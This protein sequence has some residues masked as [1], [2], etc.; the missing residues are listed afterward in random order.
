MK[1][2]KLLLTT[3]LLLGSAIL[4]STQNA[5]IGDQPILNVQAAT[6]AN[7]ETINDVM[8][9]QQLQKLVLYEMKRQKIVTSD[10][11][12]SQ[13]DAGSFKTALGKLTSINWRTIPGYQRAD[14]EPINGGNGTIGPAS[15]NPGNYSL[16]GLENATNL[17]ELDLAHD[18]DYG[19]YYFDDVKDVT[20]LSGLTKLTDLNLEGNRI[21]DISPIAG[22][23]SVKNL[24]L[25]S[26]SIKN[27]NVLDRDNYDKFQYLGQHVVFPVQHLT[28]N[29]YTWKAPFKDA[30]PKHVADPTNH[31]EP[32]TS[33]NIHMVKSSNYYDLGG[34]AGE[35]DETDLIQVFKPA[36]QNMTLD[37]DDVHFAGLAEQVSPGEGISLAQ[38]G[39][40]VPEPGNGGVVAPSR[41]A[42]HINGTLLANEHTYYMMVKYRAE[43]ERAGYSTAVMS[44]H[45]PYVIDKVQVQ[46]VTVKYEDEKGTAIHGVQTITGKLGDSFDL[47]KTDYQ[48][49][50]PGYTFKA[51]DPIQTGEL[52]GQAQTV[53]LVYTKNTAPDVPVVPKNESINPPTAPD[54]PKTPSVP[55]QPVMTE[56]TSERQT[57]VAAPEN[58]AKIHE[59][60]YSLEKIYLYQNPTFKSSERKAGYVQKPRVFRPMF[61][62]DGYAH[63]KDGRL[64]YHVRDV[65]HQSKTDG[66]RGYITTQFAYVR[67][68]Y[69]HSSHKTL[70]A[71]NPKGVNEYTNKNLTNKVRNFK[72]GTVLR[73]KKFVTHNLTTR[74][75]LTNGH[76]VTGNRKLV[77]MGR[78]KQPKQVV[79]KQGLNRYRDADFTMKNG[80]FDKGDKIIVKRFT[81]SHQDS[82]K[83]GGTKRFEVKGGFISANPKLVR[84]YYK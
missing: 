40:L 83:Q 51:Y 39:G 44:Y 16:K 10:S 17:T 30:L 26:N 33:Q 50:I 79:L 27:L 37:G 23:R 78:H 71:I 14:Y 73:V 59:A 41:E 57:Q 46:P 4:F 12:L 2:H 29:A 48:L 74:Y 67:P 81:F 76:Y 19:R 80:H 84:A 13:F 6:V 1:I 62:V 24:I 25:I 18:L 77:K 32:Y 61:V 9:N 66:L 11:D 36:T 22:M 45:L 60:V 65:N 21:E 53:K 55:D 34:Y 49:E 35:E 52:T 47:S 43:P 64:R 5:G 58:V 3:T 68:V 54:K 72:Q 38:Q 82:I 15:V 8:P 31:W 75:Q 20:P 7:E 70:T 69:Y 42:A 56:P 63:S 28:E